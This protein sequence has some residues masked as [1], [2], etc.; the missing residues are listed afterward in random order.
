M[1][2]TRKYTEE[3]LHELATGLF[4][5]GYRFIE[6]YKFLKERTDDTEL[7]SKIVASIKSNQKAIEKRQEELKSKDKEFNYLTGSNSYFDLLMGIVLIV[8]GFIFTRLIFEAGK[9]HT[10]SFGLF[11]LGIGMFGRGLF[12]LFKK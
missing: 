8:L 10:L 6:I 12:N 9:I 5:D 2:S 1:N 4:S 3:E 7:I 11:A